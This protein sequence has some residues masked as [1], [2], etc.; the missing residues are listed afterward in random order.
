LGKSPF[1]LA[2]RRY[3]GREGLE[4]GERCMSVEELQT[5]SLVGGDQHLQEQPPIEPR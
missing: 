1:D 3:P 5:V 4:V 2:Q